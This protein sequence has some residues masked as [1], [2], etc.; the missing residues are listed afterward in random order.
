M[1]LNLHCGSLWQEQLVS[2]IARRGYSFYVGKRWKFFKGLLMLFF[3]ILFLFAMQIIWVRE[4]RV[5][6][7][8]KQIRIWVI[9]IKN[10]GFNHVS[11]V[12]QS[13]MVARMYTFILRVL[14]VRNRT[15]WWLHL[16]LSQCRCVFESTIQNTNNGI[17]ILLNTARNG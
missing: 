2:A 14:A 10:K 6:L 1:G 13:I 5:K 3:V 17:M 8:T 15:L 7:R 12:H 4:V 16:P 11:L 9:F